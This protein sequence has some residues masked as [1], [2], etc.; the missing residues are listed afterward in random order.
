MHHNLVY[1]GRIREDRA[2]AWLAVVLEGNGAGERRPQECEGFTNNL[3]KLHR[4]TYGRALAAKGQQLLDNLL[5]P[6]AGLKN[7]LQVVPR[8]TFW[9]YII[10]GQFSKTNDGRQDIVEFMRDPCG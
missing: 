4:L 7:L 2:S 1:L 10:N 6:Q 3:V 9:E 5:G 8:P